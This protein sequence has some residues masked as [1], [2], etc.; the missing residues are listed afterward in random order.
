[1][2]T[3]GERLES[4]RKDLR[5]SKAELARRSGCT[6]QNIGQ[7]IS[8][9][10][11]GAVAP[12]T[13]FALADALM[14]SPRWLALGRGPREA[15][16]AIDTERLIELTQSVFEETGSLEHSWSLRRR[17]ALAVRLYELWART[18]S[19]PSVAHAVTLFQPLD[20]TSE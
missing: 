2:I 9:Q 12:E 18:G 11:R 20:Q 3:L 5:L 15:R 19:V 6:Q 7:L 17:L 16:A 13:L 14:V 4:A 10:N 1:M 8:G